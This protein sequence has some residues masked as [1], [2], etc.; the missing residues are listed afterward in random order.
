MQKQYKYLLFDLDDTLVDDYENRAYAF[1]KILKSRKEKVTKEK[2]DKFIELDKQFWK[3]RVVEKIKDPYNF[4]TKEEQTK[5]VRAQRFLMY[6]KNI[7]LKE[8]IKINEEYEET[9]KEKVVPIQNSTNILKY[10]YDKQYKIYITTNGPKCAVESKLEKSNLKQYITDT[11]SA[12]EIGFMKPKKEFYEGFFNKVNLKEK[13]DMLM[14]GDELDKD[15]K[16]GIANQIDTCW[17][18]RE[19]IENTSTIKPKYEIRDLLE[20]KEIV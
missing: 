5:W 8:A 4:E 16:G 9:I 10:L 17:F 6:F 19:S 11:F 15:I 7:S 12:E 14:I 18:N 20:L 3:D 13:E 1:S 2:I